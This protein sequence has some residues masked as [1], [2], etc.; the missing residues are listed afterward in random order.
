MRLLNLFVDKDLEPNI[1]CTLLI[2]VSK[3]L[4]DFG[5]WHASFWPIFVKKSLKALAIRIYYKHQLS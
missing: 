1:T 2:Y 4:D 3:V 5:I